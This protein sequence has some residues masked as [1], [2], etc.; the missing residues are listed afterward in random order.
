MSRLIASFFILILSI[1]VL[2]V[3]EIGKVLFKGQLTEEIHPEDS[4]APD[5]DLEDLLLYTPPTSPEHNTVYQ[6]SRK[7]STVILIH[8]HLCESLPDYHYPDIFTPPPNC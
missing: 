2:P 6:N 4:C 3:K 7:L 5:A 1:Q 8:I